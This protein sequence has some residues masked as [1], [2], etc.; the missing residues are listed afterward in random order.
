MSTYKVGMRKMS[1]RFFSDMKLL[2]Q[3]ILKHENNQYY[4]NDYDGCVR[5]L[6]TEEGILDFKP[7][8]ST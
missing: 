2:G 3:K 1:L 5:A 7:T 8:S 6:L 4:N